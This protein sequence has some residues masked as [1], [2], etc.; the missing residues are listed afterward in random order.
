MSLSLVPHPLY[1]CALILNVASF[2]AFRRMEKLIDQRRE[3]C[4]KYF[5]ANGVRIRN[6]YKFNNLLISFIHSIIASVGS[7]IILLQHP[8]LCWDFVHEFHLLA[9]LFPCLSCGYFVADLLTN[10]VKRKLFNRSW[11]DCSEI[12]VHH[13]VVTTDLLIAQSYMQYVGGLMTALLAEV[14]NIFLH[15]RSFLI[16]LDVPIG[17]GS[18]H[19]WITHS[20]LITSLLFRCFPLVLIT[21]RFTF[22]LPN[23][24]PDI[25]ELDLF[26]VTISLLLLFTYKNA[27]TW[28]IVRRD[29]RALLA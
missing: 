21:Y 3:K 4:E 17:S 11:K 5:A 28:R 15:L 6:W 10:I 14:N 12:I 20:N 19:I 1:L 9:Y 18:S 23:L 16:L 7:L 26:M 2:V 29:Y 13:F 8:T 27:L 25:P 22:D 24:Y